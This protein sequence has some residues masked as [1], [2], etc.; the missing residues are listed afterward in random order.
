MP[1][2][3][4]GAAPLVGVG[5]E[6][7]AAAKPQGSRDASVS[8]PEDITTLSANAKAVPSLVSTALSSAE[9]RAVKVETLRQAVA[10]AT[11][12][13]DAS[14]VADALLKAGI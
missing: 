2:E 8:V 10:S 13:V 3:L 9:A 6:T 7:G 4:L 5:Q 1:I 12:S 14:L 11:Y